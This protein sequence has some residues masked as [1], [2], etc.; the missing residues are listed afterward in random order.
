MG[1]LFYFIFLNN[2]LSLYSTNMAKDLR[3]FRVT[4]VEDRP[5][6]YSLHP[7]MLVIPVGKERMIRSSKRFLKRGILVVAVGQDILKKS[8]RNWQAS[9]ILL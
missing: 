2:S 1:F 4:C 6:T 3:I 7:K 9:M 8:S 5:Q